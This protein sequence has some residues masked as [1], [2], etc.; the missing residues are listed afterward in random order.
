MGYV[1]AGEHPARFSAFDV[2]AEDEIALVA[3]GA[4]GAVE[5]L[6]DGCHVSPASRLSVVR[7]RKRVGGFNLPGI[8]VESQTVL[9]DGHEQPLSA[10]RQVAAV[11]GGV[12]SHGAGDFPPPKLHAVIDVVCHHDVLALHEDPTVDR[13]RTC[14]PSVPVHH[15]SRPRAAEPQHTQRALDDLI[16]AAG[17]VGRI[18]VKVRP[19]SGPG[20]RSTHRLPLR[21]YGDSTQRL[22]HPGDLVAIQHRLAGDYRRFRD[23]QISEV[24]G[25]GHVVQ[26]VLLDAHLAPL[27]AGGVDCP[28]R[29]GDLIG[30]GVHGIDHQFRPLGQFQGQLSGLQAGHKAVSSFDAGRIDDLLGS[31]RELGRQGGIGKRIC[32]NLLDD[33]T[34]L[35]RSLGAETIDQPLVGTDE[36]P[37]GGHGQSFGRSFQLSCP[38]HLSGGGLNGDHFVNSS[39]QQH[40]AGQ[41]QRI[42][43]LAGQLPEGRGGEFPLGLVDLPNQLGGF[44]LQFVAGS[45]PDFHVYRGLASLERFQLA[46]GG[47]KRLAVQGRKL[48]SGGHVSQVSGNDQPASGEGGELVPRI[49]PIADY[50]LGAGV[51]FLSGQESVGSADRF[52]E[53]GD[54]LQLTVAS[55]EGCRRDTRHGGVDRA[56]RSQQVALRRDSALR[57]LATGVVPP[58]FGTVRCVQCVQKNTFGRKNPGRQVGHAV[59]DQHAGAKRP[60]RDHLS[61]S[62]H[63]PVVGSGPELP[64]QRPVGGVQTVGVAVVGADENASLGNRGRQS[65]RTVG[66]ARPADAAGSR[67][68]AIQLAVGRRAE[69]DRPAGHGDLESVVEVYPPKFQIAFHGIGLGITPGRFRCTS[70]L[71]HPAF[72]KWRLDPVGGHAT[73][74]RIVAIGGPI[75]GP[76]GAEARCHD[77]ERQ[78][79]TAH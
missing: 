68:Q 35:R 65:D 10:Q 51:D 8:Q 54:I 23:D 31:L 30:V 59:V 19:T 5:S 24:V 17:R 29:G 58:D 44:L 43:T 79:C 25:I 56:G 76:S 53:I 73:S 7:R 6:T 2:E 60:K 62:Q 64:R 67:V 33:R 38:K 78:P 46:A 77:Q 57:S 18:G 75:A 61:A 36:Q 9:A 32:V 49:S 50:F 37:V 42:L 26:R 45:L 39:G 20:K 14:R 21:R 1:L 72:E 15:A 27:E 3:A 48:A 34:G 52:S 22:S 41:D 28:A 12:Y 16:V 70:R 13:Q 66:E 71:E 40:V 69:V 63:A 74:S 47:R 55:I 4:S 11:A